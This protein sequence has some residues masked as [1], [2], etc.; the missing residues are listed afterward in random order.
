MQRFESVCVLGGAGLVGYQ[1]CRE[2]LS[3]GVTDRVCVVSL[4]RGEVQEAVA[5]LREEYPSATVDGRYGNVFA[6]GTLAD[7]ATEEG[8]PVGDRDDPGRRRALLSDIYED[9][10]GARA[11]SALCRLV[12]DWKP[13]AVV[14]C[15]NT[16]TAISY[17]DVPSTAKQLMA[18][19]GLRGDVEGTT[20]QLHEDVHRVASRQGRLAIE[21][22]K[23]F[24]R[25]LAL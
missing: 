13:A 24:E 19:L 20:E 23:L 16:A 12:R 1:V 3:Q 2:L 15:I 5:R 11:E 21:R 7:A 6:R 8:E 9:F 25:D 14:D 4:G 18:A 22:L 17:Q 10:E